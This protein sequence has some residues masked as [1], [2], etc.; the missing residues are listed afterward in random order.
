MLRPIDEHLL[1][2]IFVSWPDTDGKV[3]LLDLVSRGRHGNL[4][5]LKIL[6]GQGANY[7]EVDVIQRVQVIG[8][9]KC[10][11][12]VG[13]NNFTGIDWEGKFVG[14]TKKSWAKAYMTLMTTIP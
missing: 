8:I 6:T 10:H 13:L 14:I 3:L 4:N 2:E 9:Q 1:Q 7:R 11:G 5:S 12:L